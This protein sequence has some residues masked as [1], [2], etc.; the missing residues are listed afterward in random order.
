MKTKD[1]VHHRKIDQTWIAYRRVELEDRN[2]LPDLFLGLKRDVPEEVIT[3]PPFCIIQFVTSVTDCI[4][5]EI[6]FPV[7]E[8]FGEASDIT[9][10]LPEK[11]VL[12]LVHEGPVAE[13][14]P[15][16][17]TLFGWASTRGII[18]DE[19]CQEVYLD[20]E[21]MKGIEIQFVIHSW[22]RLLDNHL[23]R[24]LGE[25]AASQVISGREVLTINASVEDRFQWVKNAVT[26]LDQ[27][28]GDGECFEILSR[29]AHVFPAS[30]IAKLR[31]VFL[32]VEYRGGDFLESVDA[33]LDFME[34]DPG[35]GEGA[36]REGYTI[37]S[38]KGPRDPAGYEKATTVEEKKKAYC[39]C[40]LIRENLEGG[41]PPGFCYCG[42]G[43][44]RQQW[45]GVLDQPVKI[46]IV[47]SL[48]QGDELC[49][50]AI[51]LPHAA[52]A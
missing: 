42:S 35:W 1:Q 24:V 16:Y 39:F 3:G 46:E 52:R 5:A 18:S 21:H 9:R 51:I 47:R 27:A 12:A 8:A 33:V 44:Y 49:E 2:Q 4:D 37:Y 26:N 40:P 28:A 50:F 45:E 29:C 15:S 41:M 11:E 20:L 34:R 22:E 7:R 14:G 36:R 38:A 32:E 43:W 30:Q 19:F 6:C 31:E 23:V 10:L 25:E 13:L 48:L 17:R